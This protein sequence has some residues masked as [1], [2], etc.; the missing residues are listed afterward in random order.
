MPPYSKLINPYRPLLIDLLLAIINDLHTPLLMGY[1]PCSLFHSNS[2]HL[3][4]W[5]FRHIPIIIPK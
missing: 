4:N 2:P 3:P 1:E 5:N